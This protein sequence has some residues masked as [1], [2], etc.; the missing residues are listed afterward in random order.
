MLMRYWSFLTEP[1]RNRTKNEDAGDIASLESELEI[2]KVRS[3]VLP[4]ARTLFSSAA[5]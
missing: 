1:D 3:T 4:S 2:I 5:L